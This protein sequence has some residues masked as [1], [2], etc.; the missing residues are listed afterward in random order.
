M[1]VA[2]ENEVKQNCGIKGTEPLN[3]IK[4]GSEG[5]IKIAPGDIKDWYIR[6]EIPETAPLCIVRFN[7]NVDA[8]G[9]YYYADSF[10]V[11]I[12]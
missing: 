2:N 9:E 1:T 7:I 10:D 11:K 12:K 3:W 4:A 8:D 5:E 6:F